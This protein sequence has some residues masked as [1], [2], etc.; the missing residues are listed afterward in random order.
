LARRRETRYLMENDEE[1]L[2]LEIKTDVDIVKEQATWA[3]L[4]QGMRILD[5]GC[6]IGKT[7]RALYDLA[8][9]AA[10]AVGIDF[11]EERIGHAENVGNHE[12]LQFICR[13]INRPIDDLGEFD[14]IWIRFVL[15]YFKTNAQS[16]V[17]NVTKVLR[18]GGILCLIDLDYNAMNHFEMPARLEKAVLTS[19]KMLE[20]QADF[21]PYIGR[22]LYSYLFD[23]SYT[24]ISVS[25]GAHHLI[26]G[27]LNSTDSFN[28]TKK[29]EVLSREIDFQ[30][31]EYH[32]GFPEFA[33]EFQTFFSDKRRFSYT[34]IILA[35]GCKP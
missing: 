8:Q 31:P 29:L 10:K 30:F 18:K 11:S 14:F 17:Q 24:D 12:A 20:Q 25:V 34:P 9:P 23:L 19:I 5:V 6:G 27:D 28:W 1:S 22:K 7:T 35:R 32:G 15:E 16:I 21:D 26:Y 2:R 3:G 33:E 13:D 4:R